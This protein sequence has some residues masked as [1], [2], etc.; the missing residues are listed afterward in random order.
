[1]PIIYNPGPFFLLAWGIC[2]ISSTKQSQFLFLG[3]LMI[4]TDIKADILLV[5]PKRIAH[6]FDFTLAISP[7]M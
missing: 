1:M 3:Q 5:Q 2:I 4:I 6:L 7:H